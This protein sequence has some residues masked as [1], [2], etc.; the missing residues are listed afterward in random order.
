MRLLPHMAR[1]ATSPLASWNSV[2]G[3]TIVPLGVT[4]A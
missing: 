4:L 3:I 1:S 2:Y